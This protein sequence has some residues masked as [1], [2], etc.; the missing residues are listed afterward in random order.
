MSTHRDDTPSATLFNELQELLHQEDNKQRAFR[1]W[2][3]VLEASGNSDFAVVFDF[4]LEKELIL[5]VDPGGKSADGQPRGS[6]IWTNPVDG[7]QMVWIPPGPFYVGKEKEHRAE[8][9]GF[10]LARHPVTNAQFKRFL[11]ATG[12][13]PPEGHPSPA[14]FLSHWRERTFGSGSAP[15]PNP[16]VWVSY[17]DALHYC[18]WAGLTLPTEWMWE[19]AARGPD[20]RD[21]PWGETCP[22]DRQKLTNVNGACT[23]GVGAFPRTR[24]A[25][26]CEDMIG[27]V[28]E[29]C[30]TTGDGDFDHM[31]PGLPD[32]DL[33][34]EQE[35]VYAAVRGSCFLR[36]SPSRMTCWHRRRLSITRRNQWVGF[37]P[38]LPL[39]CR[40]AL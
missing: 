17:L 12:Y 37:R 18:R 27:N 22:V 21:Y 8:C 1:A 30:Q 31:P 16:V 25:Y 7:S 19:K 36:S 26:G 38:A 40:P 13:T 9:R 33:D 32:L 15:E 2:Q 23:C 11:D 39:P 4:A 3:I 24:T 20:G 5:P 28:S 10:S 29:W 14:L 35:G 6:T 34:L